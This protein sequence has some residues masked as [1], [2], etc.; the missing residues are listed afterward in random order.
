M[1]S[2][3]CVKDTISLFPRAADLDI[4]DIAL[5]TVVYN[6]NHACCEWSKTTTTKGL[7][8]STSKKALFANANKRISQF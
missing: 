1:A 2:K 8:M 6:N 7:K 3:Y 5:P 4:P